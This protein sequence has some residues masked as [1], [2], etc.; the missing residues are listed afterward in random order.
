[1]GESP[2]AEAVVDDTAYPTGQ[3]PARV[4]TLRSVAIQPEGVAGRVGVRPVVALVLHGGSA[5]AQRQLLRGLQVV[6]RKVQMQLMGMLGIG[7]AGRSVLLRSI[8]EGQAWKA[9]LVPGDH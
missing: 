8:T 6:H 4:L 3:R 9:A 1:G 5:Q 7:P 2:R